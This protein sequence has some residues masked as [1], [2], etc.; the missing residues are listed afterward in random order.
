M[1]VLED[2]LLA[3]THT[4]GWNWKMKTRDNANRTAPS[5]RQKLHPA[6]EEV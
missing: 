2:A 6:K 3:F 4:L 1:S 5:G